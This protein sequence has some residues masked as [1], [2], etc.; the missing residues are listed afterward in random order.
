VRVL[1][2]SPFPPWPPD[3]G[4]IRIRELVRGLAAVH[5]VSLLALSDGGPED[6]A[7]MAALEEEGIPI[8]AVVSRP[9]RRVVAAGAVLAGRS[10]H[11]SLV[12]SPQ[13]RRR[14]ADRLADG[15]V[16]V[17]Q[18][19][20]SSMAA[21]RD[22]GRRVPWVLDALNVEFRVNESLARTARASIGYRWYA[23]REARCRRREELAAWRA[24]D[25]VVT[26]S[27][28]DR[29]IVEDLAPGSPVTVVPNGVDLARLRPPT[30]AA[31]LPPR[32]VFVGKMDYRPNVEGI[33]WFVDEVLPRIRERVPAFEL[34]VVGRNPAP[35]VAA[36]GARDGVS[37]VGAVP[38]PTPHLHGATVA[39]VP[40]RA[41][42]GTRLKVLEALAAG[43]PVVSTPLG[44]EGL[45][46]VAGRHVLV[47][48][49]TEGFAG[50]VVALLGDRDRR[51]GL[52][53]AG[54]RLV[55]ERYGWPAAVQTLLE[56]HERLA[57]ER[58]PTGRG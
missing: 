5:D 47:A 39:V 45:D 56:V 10:V 42:S 24:V 38:D 55:E 41:G 44:V 15:S 46:V 40:L 3:G 7:G 26:V 35:A 33:G 12:R 2:L 52:A 36:L 30:G 1:V 28:D 27:E 51:A 37:I 53:R 50:A 48:E 17:V 16:D 58:R 19:E 43:T 21:Y 18:C 32:A 57:E 11:G 9:D 34:A 31:D 14:L 23:R 49:G 22:V 6:E 29:R 13:L 4:R 25:H 8:E 20:L 54:R